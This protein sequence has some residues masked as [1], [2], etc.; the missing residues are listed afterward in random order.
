[1]CFNG[2]EDCIRIARDYYEKWLQTGEPMPSSFKRLILETVIRY[3]DDA[4][5]YRVYEKAISSESPTE[6]LGMLRTLTVSRNP[7]LLEK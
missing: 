5:W 3:G 2:N 6:R 4:D 1:M 7:L